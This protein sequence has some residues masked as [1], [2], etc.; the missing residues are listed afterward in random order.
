[1]RLLQHITILDFSRL[2]PGPFL[3]R[4][5]ADLGARVIKIEDPKRKDYMDVFPPHLFEGESSLGVAL[6]HG[7]ERVQVDFES[8]DGQAF[9]TKLLGQSDVVIES[10]RPGMMKS[11]GLDFARLKRKHTKLLYVSLTGFSLKSAQQQQAGH[12][13]NFLAESGFLN[14][15][16]SAGV[17]PSLPLADF[18][19]GGLFGVIQILSRLSARKRRAEHLKLS[20]SEAMAYLVPFG[21]YLQQG[22]DVLNGELARYRSYLSSDAVVVTLAALEDK[23]WKRFVSLIGKEEWS[24][25]GYDPVQNRKIIPA[26][27]EIVASRTAAQWRQLATTHD[28]CMTIMSETNA[29]TNDIMSIRY[30]KQTKSIPRSNYFGK[31]AK[32]Q[33]GARGCDNR[34]ILM[35]CGYT[36]ASIKRILKNGVI[37]GLL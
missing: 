24:D 14:L 2:I 9:L 15:L 13:L 4:I 37:G 3:T 30:Q 33:Y 35:E 17:L 32:S 21:E 25:V 27:S 12:D 29:E 19:G 1:M 36:A 34:K 6:N 22:G 23:F 10:F 5:L 26:L 16:P 28:I 20:M 11:F 18:V 7:K 31:A 8:K